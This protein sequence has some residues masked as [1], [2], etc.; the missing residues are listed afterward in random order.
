MLLKKSIGYVVARGIPG[1]LT[2]ASLALY[3]RILLP[4][5]YGLYTLVLFSVVFI[6]SLLFNWAGVS[7]I[8]FS[9]RD[10]GEF[11][12]ILVSNIRII[13]IFI[14][15][16]ASIM[17]LF[18]VPY[19]NLSSPTWSITAVVAILIVTE[20][21]HNLSLKLAV[22][23]ITP[24][25][26]GQ[27][28]VIRAT[29]ALVVG[30]SMAALGLGA[31]GALAG[32]ALGGLLSILWP[33]VMRNWARASS[34]RLRPGLIK[35]MMA[36]GFPLA[37]TFALNFVVGYSDRY[38]LAALS[39]RTSV[40]LYA[41]GYDLATL[42]MAIMAPISMAAYP[43]IVR[44][45]ER[46]GSAV[47]KQRLSDN[48]DLLLL[49]AIPMLILLTVYSKDLID[50]V[51][52]AE[53]RDAA[54]RI[55]PIV[56]PAILLAGIRSYHLD[57]A[58]HL[59]KCTWAILLVIGM[60]AITNVTMNFLLIPIYG[61]DGAAYATLVAYIVAFIFSLLLGL[62]FG[63]RLPGLKWQTLR[64]CLAGLGTTFIC[65]QVSFR[66]LWGFV[67]EVIIMVSVFFALLVL[68]RVNI[69]LHTLRQLVLRSRRI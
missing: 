49:S 31:K 11:F 24:L 36:Y 29:T 12:N 43:L 40:G 45:L 6:D 56:G 4:E 38:L 1:L 48:L 51:I 7:L 39:G 2:F 57:V 13:F 10:D 54:A 63:F 5:E 55:T 28:A 67:A 14:T 21:W 62:R 66:S 30:G 58:F 68:F 3:S 16:S 60:A 52:G 25:R 61:I 19:L 42:G 26:Y 64:I 9:Q 50:I 27:I 20:P 41:A 69:V 53:F 44:G 17:S 59:K 23:E 35:E 22:A 37:L 33:S 8:R 18:I 46:D 32:V 47:A 34:Q 15:I 65:M